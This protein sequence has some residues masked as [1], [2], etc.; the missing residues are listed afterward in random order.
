MDRKSLWKWLIFAVITVFSVA[1]IWPPMPT[2]DSAGVKHPGKIRLGLD[3]QGGSSFTVQ[4]DIPKLREQLRDR[5]MEDGKRE[6]VTEAELDNVVNR[7]LLESDAR[8][9]EVLR[10]RVDTLGVNEPV[11]TA[12]KDHRI[13]IQLPSAD[14]QQRDEAEKRILS[15][16]FLQFRLVHKNNDELVRAL[17]TA[18]KVPEGYRMASDGGNAYEPVSSKLVE[19]QKDPSYARRLG[20]FEAPDP[21]YE[22][23]LEKVFAKEGGRT[24][25]RVVYRPFFVRRKAEMTGDSLSKASDE[26]DPRNGSMEVSLTFKKEGALQFER[27]TGERVGR[28]LAIV[29]DSAL[30]SAP[31]IRERISGGQARISGAFTLLE[32]RRLRDVLNAG[33][34]PTP[35]TIIERHM[36]GSTLGADAIQS[37]VRAAFVGCILVCAFML[38]YYMYCG[39]VANLALLMDIVLLPAGMLLTA[40]LL[41][42]LVHEGGT[43]AGVL[44]LPVLTMPGIAGIVLTI[45]MAVDANVLI[46]ERMREEFRAGKS[47]RAAIAAGYDRAFFAIFD[48]SITTIISGVIMFVF[49]SGPVRGYAITLCAGVLVS[50]YSSL[51]VTRMVFEATSSDSRVRPYRMMSW[52]KESTIDFLAAKKTAILFSTAVIAITLSIF[53]WNVWCNPRRVLAVDFT[54]GTTLTFNFDQRASLEAVTQAA[55]AAG[56]S[57][58]MSQYQTAL[59][60]SAGVLLIKTSLPAGKDGYVVSQALAASLRQSIPASNFRLVGQEEIGSQI[61]AELARD[62]MIAIGLALVAIIIYLTIRFEFGFALGAIVAVFHDALFTLGVY[63]LCDRQLSLTIVAALLTIIGYSVND[64]IVIF[65]RIR[66]NLKLDQR[67]SFVEICNLS[68]NQTLG[69]TLLT[70]LTVLLAVLSLFFLGGGAINDFAL[71][72]LIGVIVGTYSTIYIATPVTLAWHRGRRPSMG[73]PVKK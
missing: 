47:M 65:D 37:G 21:S 69:R 33:S 51:V 49:G 5:L 34:L 59:D 72:M 45:G 16:A 26:L 35:V 9:L 18:G 61:S 3:L 48:S 57:D 22:F 20:T 31:V 32:A 15:A 30:C 13:L 41:R 14:E 2:V 10:N 36:V 1:V 70:N 55:A 25:D 39:F 66:E 42:V 62:G 58:A 7:A 53:V 73:S 24:L 50:M 46:F 60:G 8:V 64:T 52:I 54:G 6:T 29:L 19:L 43:G 23:M 40:G 4:V 71:F 44:Q 11:I 67:K 17:F 12:G 68:I 63:C 38:F 27:V 56:L 28:Q